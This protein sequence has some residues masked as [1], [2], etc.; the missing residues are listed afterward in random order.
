M[1]HDPVHS[2]H[3]SVCLEQDSH[4]GLGKKMFPEFAQESP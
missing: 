2:T 4:V 1:T 3:G